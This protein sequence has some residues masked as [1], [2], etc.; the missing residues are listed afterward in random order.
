MLFRSD[1]VLTVSNTNAH[2]AGA[3]GKPTWVLL[4]V[5]GARLWYWFRGRQ[6][7]PWYPRVHLKRR[8][9][10]QSWTDLVAA[11]APEIEA[12]LRA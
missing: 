11:A 9:R 1:L 8:T 5:G 3:L 2:L 10:G 7:S 4:P 6:Y 12:A